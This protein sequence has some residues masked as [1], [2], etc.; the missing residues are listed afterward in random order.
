MLNGVLIIKTHDLTQSQKHSI[1]MLLK[2]ENICVVQCN[3]SVSFAVPFTS[4]KDT[5][6]MILGT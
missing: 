2:I 5:K 3:G 6:K 1:A 4:S